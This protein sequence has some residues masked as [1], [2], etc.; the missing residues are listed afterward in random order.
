MM[1]LTVTYKH[2]VL[3]LKIHIEEVKSQRNDNTSYKNV[4]MK[5]GL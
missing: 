3:T 2:M 4:E 5:L 1:V